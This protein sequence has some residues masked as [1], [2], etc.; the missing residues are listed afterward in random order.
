MFI[1]VKTVDGELTTNQSRE[2]K[3]LK[4]VGAAVGTV[5]GK[6]QVDQL[7]EELKKVGDV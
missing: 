1:E 6:E 4:D 2:H 5:Y 7:I 3:R